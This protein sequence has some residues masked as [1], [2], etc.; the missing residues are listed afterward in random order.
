M[1]SGWRMG[2]SVEDPYRKD[3]ELLEGLLPA[4]SYWEKL[5]IFLYLLLRGCWSSDLWQLVVSLNK[6]MRYVNAHIATIVSRKCYLINTQ[7]TDLLTMHV[8]YF[9]DV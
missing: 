9:R 2:P 8:T 3:K 6:Y 5:A 4:H 7:T 1:E